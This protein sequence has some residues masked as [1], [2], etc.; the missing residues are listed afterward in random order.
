METTCKAEIIQ[1]KSISHSF[2][3]NGYSEIR[4]YYDVAGPDY[5]TW[6]R[7]FNMHFGYCKSFSD[8]FHLERML[9]N[10]NEEVLKQLHIRPDEKARKVF[11]LSGFIN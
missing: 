7:N 4:K 8:I 6:S 10:M 9:V 2:P 3:L 1:K 11:F 5:E